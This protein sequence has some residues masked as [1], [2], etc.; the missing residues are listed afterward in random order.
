MVLTQLSILH[1]VIRI[2][3][4]KKKQFCVTFI[5]HVPFE[6]TALYI[7]FRSLESE[8]VMIMILFPLTS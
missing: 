2:C 1:I 3:R 5:L 8:R 4:L 6:H 7:Q